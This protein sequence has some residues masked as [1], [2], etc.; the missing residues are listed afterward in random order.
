MLATKKS[1]TTPEFESRK[2][3]GIRMEKALL[4]LSRGTTLLEL[5]FNGGRE[6]RHVMMELRRRL[7]DY[8]FH[9]LNYGDKVIPR[10]SKFLPR[11]SGWIFLYLYIMLTRTSL[12]R[13]DIPAM[14]STLS[15]KA[16]MD[17]VPRMLLNFVSN[18]RL[19]PNH[20]ALCLQLA[21]ITGYNG[22]YLKSEDS[23]DILQ[24]AN[25]FGVYVTD[26]INVDHATT[27]VE[28]HLLSES[29]ESVSAICTAILPEVDRQKFYRAMTLNRVTM[30]SEFG[31]DQVFAVPAKDSDCARM[32]HAYLFSVGLSTEQNPDEGL[33]AIIGTYISF[34]R[35]TISEGCVPQPRDKELEAIWV[36]RLGIDID[37]S[38]SSDLPGVVL[39]VTHLIA[40]SVMP[41]GLVNSVN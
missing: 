19:W 18:H 33:L 37:Q 2:L 14:C 10:S 22:V 8:V 32:I 25:M 24:A 38:L 40:V 35:R 7:D 3:V 29:V 41:A 36:K 11:M 1:R 27:L 6:D 16:V 20:Q 9:Y 23:A 12:S 39:R 5:G 30:G 15:K 13:G 17:K 26:T 4:D 28:E 21:G 34:V 31:G